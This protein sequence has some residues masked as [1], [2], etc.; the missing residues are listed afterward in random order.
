M[1]EVVF[2]VLKGAEL[3]GV[4]ASEEIALEAAG[5]QR[6]YVIPCDVLEEAP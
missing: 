3:V 4:Y 1:S 6:E 5:G 2:V